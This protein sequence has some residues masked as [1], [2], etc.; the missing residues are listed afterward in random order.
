MKLMSWEGWTTPMS[1]SCL[2]FTRP[3][4]T[5]IWCCLIWRVASFLSE[6]KVRSN[7]QNQ[8]R[9]WLW[10]V[11]CLHLSTWLKIR[12]S[13]EISSLKIW[14]LLNEGTTISSKSRISAWRVF[15]PKR[16]R[17]CTCAVVL[18]ATCPLSFWMTKAMTA[19]QMCSPQASSC[20][21][22]LRGGHCLEV[23][24]SMKF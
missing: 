14:F 12:S 8:T 15:S 2:L 3:P 23:I 5:C 19:K 9:Q 20:T 16:R 24:T 1:S 13:T 11:F 18:Q 17:S 7:I 21:W 4:S 10:S 22:C 6:S